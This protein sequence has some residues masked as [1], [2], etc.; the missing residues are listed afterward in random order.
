MPPMTGDDAAGAARAVD[1]ELQRLLAAGRDREAA[2]VGA[3]AHPTGTDRGPGGTMDTI[4]QLEV[5][6]ADAER[7]G[8]GIGPDDMDRPSP[9]ADFR[10]RELFGHMIAGASQFA[11]Q[12]RG[13]QPT[14]T[15]PDVGGMTS[16]EASAAF[17][18]ALDDLLAAAKAPGAF[19]RTVTLPFGAVPGEVLAR[20]LTV[21]GMVHT[22]DLAR[23]SGQRY[24]P[25]DELAGEV[26]ATARALIAPPM[27][28]GD[29]FKDEVEA[30]AGASNLDRLVAF[31]GRRP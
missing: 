5:I 27:R 2:A 26:L 3:A 15:P 4:Q 11:P 28:D 22:W 29:T 14:G 10:V 13:G 7:I 12:L 1:Q 30:P 8:D 16:A 19:D 24:A 31:T 25:S 9:C 21:D 18:A 20:F 17:R 23:A 6:F